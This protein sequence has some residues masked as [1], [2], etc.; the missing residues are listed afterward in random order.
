VNRDTVGDDFF[1]AVNRH[2]RRLTAD[3]FQVL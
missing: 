1:V 3:W 2:Y